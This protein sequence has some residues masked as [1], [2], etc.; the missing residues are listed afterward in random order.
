MLVNRDPGPGSATYFFMFCS[1]QNSLLKMND[2]S[3]RSSDYFFCDV[4]CP[5]TNARTYCK[6]PRSSR[7]AKETQH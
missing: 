7:I 2:H 4:V 3:L 1:E 6:S 5:L